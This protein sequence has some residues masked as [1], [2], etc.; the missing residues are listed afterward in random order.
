M[1]LTRFH[2]VL[3]VNSLALGFR[4]DYEN[5]SDGQNR[6][7]DRAIDLLVDDRSAFA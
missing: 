6:R 5:D 7:E 4:C 2:C 3:S 1:I